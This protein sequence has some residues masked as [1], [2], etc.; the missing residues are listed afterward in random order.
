MFYLMDF[1]L[2]YYAQSL[3]Q[4]LPG[5]DFWM[6]AVGWVLLFSLWKFTPDEWLLCA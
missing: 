6:A 2:T 3:Q 1:S 5:Q 4:L